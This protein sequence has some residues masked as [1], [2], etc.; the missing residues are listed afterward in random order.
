MVYRQPI[1]IRRLDPID[2]CVLYKGPVRLCACQRLFKPPVVKRFEQI[3]ERAGF[4][5][6]SARI[7]RRP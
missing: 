1:G 3:V 4:E 7:D 6:L 2:L 5:C